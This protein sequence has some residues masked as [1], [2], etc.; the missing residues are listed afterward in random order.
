ML[1]SLSQ[2]QRIKCV[3]FGGK[4]GVGKT[5]VSAAIAMHLSKQKRVLLVST[6]PSHSLSDIFQEDFWGGEINRISDNFHILEIDAGK[7]IKEYQEEVRNKIRE[8][9]GTIPKEI[10]DYITAVGISPAFQESA[11]FEMVIELLI[12]DEYEV[13][14]IDTAPIGHT[15]QLF[16]ST[17]IF[18]KWLN[19]ILKSREKTVEYRKVRD[20][21]EMTQTRED[22]ILSELLSIRDR[23]EKAKQFLTSP[24]K[25]SFFFV[26]V[27]EELPISETQRTMEWL[28]DLDI[29]IGGVIINQI[30]PR[31]MIGDNV[32]F[33]ERVK[34][35]E[36]Y[37][38]KID[39]IF[40]HQVAGKIYLFENE[41]QG[42]EMIEKVS[43]VLLS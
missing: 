38:E 20:K 39:K 7:R 43:D 27:P 33:S 29:P 5:T 31:D 32:L 3:L 11:I 19:K 14:V 15:F 18:E 35:Q 25:T 40:G 2:N 41:V 4:G 1:K 13:Y 24:E 21:L 22:A 37:L 30:I 16:N 36:K 17:K 34:M 8:M 6:D 9:H 10:D 28:K 26:L 23:I 12:K 42:R